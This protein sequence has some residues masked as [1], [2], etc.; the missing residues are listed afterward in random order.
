MDTIERLEAIEAIR[1]LK[2][3]YFRCL[4]AKDWAGLEA[5]FAPD[6]EVDITVDVPAEHGGR[7]R[8]AVA[9]VAFCSQAMGE[10]VSVHHGHAP[11]IEITSDTTATGIWPMEDMLRW[12]DGAEP[13]REMHGFG[14]YHETYKRIDDEW[15]IASMT[16][17]RLRTDIVP[18]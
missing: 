18:S 1:Q 10:V 16:L 14:H 6:V 9:F 17:T 15:R 12:P 7:G 13:L 3:R 11:E 4:D 2:A 8:G 5:V